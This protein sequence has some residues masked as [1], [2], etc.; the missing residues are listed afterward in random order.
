MTRASQPASARAPAALWA[1]SSSSAPSVAERDA[2]EP[3]GPARVGEPDLDGAAIDVDAGVVE[4]FEQRHRDEGVGRLVL[5]GEREPHRAVGARRGVEGD[6]EVPVRGAA[7]HALDAFRGVDQRRPGRVRG[8]DHGVE[9]V[10]GEVADDQRHPRPRNG[11]LLGGDRR[12]RVAEPRLVIQ[13]DR[14]DGGGHRITDVGGVE[15]AAEADFDDADVDPCPP[16]QLV[17]DG[18]HGFEE[19]RLVGEAA[20]GEAGGLDREH[21]GDR[22]R[23]GVRVDRNAVDGDPL[24][25]PHQVR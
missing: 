17:G 10:V 18:G 22:L 4:R 14:D 25:G 2:I 24:L 15:T 13:I 3:A 1:A 6:G 16:Q 23:E 5:A 11:R 9:R 8:R 12:P 20:V 21:V 19:G 7:D